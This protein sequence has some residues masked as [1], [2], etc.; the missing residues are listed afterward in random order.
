MSA[1]EL[2]ELNFDVTDA[3]TIIV[4]AGVT[5]SLFQDLSHLRAVPATL[6]VVDHVGGYP[7]AS[8]FPVSGTLTDPVNPSVSPA[9]F[10]YPTGSAILYTPISWTNDR[11]VQQ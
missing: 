9:R 5:L 2:R 1:E 10:G 11:F 3:Q 6:R 7:A 8:P 4:D